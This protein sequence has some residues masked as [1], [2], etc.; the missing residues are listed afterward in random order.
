MSEHT[1]SDAF[2]SAGPP[3]S[4]GFLARVGRTRRA[5][6]LGTALVVL[7]AVL[8]AY[9]AS[10]YFWHDPVTDLYARWKQHQLGSQLD[11]TFAEFR[12]T[13]DLG[14]STDGAA[15]STSTGAPATGEGGAR[16]RD[17]ELAAATR[18]AARKMLARLEPHQAVGRL[19]IPKLGVHPIFVNGTSWGADLS[20]GPGRYEQT[21]LPGLGRVTAIAGHR[22][23]FGAWFRHID[24]LSPGDTITVTLPYGTFHYAVTGYKIVANDDW[25]IITPHGFDE[26]VLSACHPLYSASHRYV[27]FARLVSVDTPAGAFAV[28]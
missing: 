3:A 22:T 7:G 19:T 21:S 12:P 26:L 18:L 9:G 23:T 16:A 14:T 24:R 6:R 20:R 15:G 1:A 10:V 4:T 28:A 27:V 13:F 25:S 11:H 8:L 2:D 5:R 17:R